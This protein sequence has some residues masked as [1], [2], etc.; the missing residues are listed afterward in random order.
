MTCSAGRRL[1]SFL[2]R[3]P[4]AGCL[5]Q[6]VDLI[7]NRQIDPG[8]VF[9]SVVRE[10]RQQ[11]PFQLLE[12]A[13]ELLTLLDPLGLQRNEVD[14]YFCQERLRSSDVEQGLGLQD[15]V[16]CTPAGGRPWTFNVT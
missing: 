15:S 13:V 5:P 3:S 9:P 12:V 14:P 6:L 4:V 16:E 1:G 11:Q 10:H 2:G 8:K 7:W